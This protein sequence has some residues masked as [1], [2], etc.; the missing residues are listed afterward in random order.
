LATRSGGGD[1]V[2]LFVWFAQKAEP[3]LDVKI[4][5]GGGGIGQ[6]MGTVRVSGWGNFEMIRDR[7]GIISRLVT[8][9]G[10]SQN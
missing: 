1:G 7:G 6:K 3:V 10:V 5:G 8:K 2:T 4:G 9:R